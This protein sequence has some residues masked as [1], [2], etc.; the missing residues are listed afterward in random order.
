ML[1][2]G[3][4][5]RQLCMLSDNLHLLNVF[6]LSVWR[7]ILYLLYLLSK[8]RWKHIRRDKN[9]RCPHCIWGIRSLHFYSRVLRQ[10]TVLIWHFQIYANQICMSWS[11]GGP[12]STL[13]FPPIVQLVWALEKMLLYTG[14][15]V[16]LLKDNRK[17]AVASGG[18]SWSLFIINVAWSIHCVSS[19]SL[20]RVLTSLPCSFIVSNHLP[21]S[22]TF[23]HS[24]SLLSPLHTRLRQLYSL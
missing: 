6:T 10:Q 20:W 1:K 8:K 14:N 13:K 7:F 23:I 24:C 22:L 17:T 5:I 3:K 19:Y 9:S 2:A 16:I 15:A 12:K 11:K 18:L 21:L 4:E